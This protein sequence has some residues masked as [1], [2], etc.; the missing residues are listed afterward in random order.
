MDIGDP[1]KAGQE[2]A[3]I[4]TTSYEALANASAANLFRAMPAPRTAQN[5]KR[6]GLPRKDKIASISDLD[7]AVARPGG[8][9]PR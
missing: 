7:N 6:I 8:P 3:L 5:L 4:D 2:L 9:V 1:V